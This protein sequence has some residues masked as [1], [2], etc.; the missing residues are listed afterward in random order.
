V[1]TQKKEGKGKMGGG[2]KEGE[3]EHSYPL[4]TASNAN[5]K[6]GPERRR[7]GKKEMFTPSF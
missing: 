1:P 2:R 6:K 5:G 4:L 7:G 3:N